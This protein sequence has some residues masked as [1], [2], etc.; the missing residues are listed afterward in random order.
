MGTIKARCIKQWKQL[1]GVLDLGDEIEITSILSTEPKVV[2][3][4]WYHH[5]DHNGKALKVAVLAA[6][7]LI[8][9][10]GTYEG[11]T[12]VSKNGNTYSHHMI[13]LCIGYFKMEKLFEKI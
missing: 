5:H 13:H 7:E 3:R 11:F 2:H 8:A 9:P 12:F 10:V 6:P 4:A 1:E